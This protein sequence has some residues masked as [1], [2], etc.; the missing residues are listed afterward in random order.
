LIKLYKR[1]D[2]VLHYW[3]TW[4]DDDTSSIVHWGKVGDRG[5]DKV[6][7]APYAKALRPLLK[8]EVE[9]VLADGYAEISD[10]ALEVL[11]IEYAVEDADKRH[12]LEDRLQ[13]TLGW[14]GAGACDGGSIGS[15]TMEVCCFVVDFGIAKKV[16]EDDLAGTP[17]GDFTRIYRESAA[18]S[19]A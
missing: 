4:D 18:S 13:E 9:R 8:D 11:L 19:A 7:S 12:A 5:Q 3:E 17:F 15:G 14:T 10:E 2:G 16:I 1:I 6:L